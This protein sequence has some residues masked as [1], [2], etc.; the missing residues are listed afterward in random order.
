MEHIKFPEN[1]PSLIVI[2]SN[3][4]GTGFLKYCYDER[5]LHGK[6]KEDE[7]DK[8]V[9]TSAKIAA[10]AYS[11]KRVMDKKGIGKFI[12]GIIA[13]SGLM[14]L[15]HVMLML[16]AADAESDLL[17]YL[18]YLLLAPSFIAMVVLTFKNWFKNV[19]TFIT[20]EEITKNNLD[21]YFEK[22]NREKFLEKGLEWSAAQLG[23]FWIELR[24]KHPRQ[25]AFVQDL[26]VTKKSQANFQRQESEEN[27]LM[28]YNDEPE[29]KLSSRRS[30]LSELSNQIKNSNRQSVSQSRFRKSHDSRIEA[31]SISDDDHNQ[32]AHDEVSHVTKTEAFHLYEDEKELEKFKKG[33]SMDDDNNS[34]S[35]GDPKV[36]SKRSKN[37]ASRKQENEENDDLA[38]DLEDLGLM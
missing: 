7:F 31:E 5:H 2:P 10:K 13:L 32:L 11:T 24:I 27:R 37:P 35:L 17:H 16:A 33:T 34:D 38:F 28:D 6:V 3:K 22:I 14:T 1:S 20:F 19:K 30:D 12:G 26:P 4:E 25:E 29:Q 23:H 21:I 8:V 9:E 15:A 36:L 18:S